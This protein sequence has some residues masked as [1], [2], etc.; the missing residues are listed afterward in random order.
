MT[1]VPS[2][3]HFLLSLCFTTD[4]SLITKFPGYMFK[5]ILETISNFF[6]S[7]FGGG[8]ASKPKP[9]PVTDKPT[10]TT[11]QIDQPADLVEDGSDVPIDTVITVDVMDV[12]IPQ[13]DGTDGGPF[14]DDDKEGAFDEGSVEPEP[15]PEPTTPE[16]PTPPPSPAHVPKYLWCLDN[17]HGKKQAGKRSPKYKEGDETVQFFE[18]EFNRDIV[19]RII[20]KLDKKGV[21]YYDVVPDYLEVGSFLKERVARANKKRSDLPRIYVSVHS[22]AGPTAPGSQWTSPSVKGAETW[23]AHNST[24]GKKV[25][26]VFQKHILAKTGFKDRKLRSTK[27]RSLYVLVKTVMPAI[28]TE[29]GFFNN[30][31]EVK[32]LMKDSVRQKI[33]DAHVAAI[34]EIEKNGI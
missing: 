15:T 33:A 25:A 11:D 12:D 24:K 14:A 18:Y 4:P 2:N 28:L 31:E 13:L 22:N 21:K 9:K 3:H 20:K 17:G 26:A 7:L 23:F 34:M 29:N 30:K 16:P 19:E 10:P 6:G 5:K 32:E 1:G 8:G 27:E